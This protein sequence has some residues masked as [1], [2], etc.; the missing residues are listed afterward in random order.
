MVQKSGGVGPKV[1][2]STV[3]PSI[4]MGIN[5]SVFSESPFHQDANHSGK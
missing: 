1:V 3:F 4:S 2:N 5:L